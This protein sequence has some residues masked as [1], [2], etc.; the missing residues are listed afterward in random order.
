MLTR[1][2]AMGAALSLAVPLTARAD[3]VPALEPFSPDGRYLPFWQAIS[4]GVAGP[5][6]AI[7]D[8]YAATLGKWFGVADSD[9]LSILPNLAHFDSAVRDLGFLG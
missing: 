5:L 8:Q 1:R 7:K 6:G 4:D 3:D 9:L 2:L